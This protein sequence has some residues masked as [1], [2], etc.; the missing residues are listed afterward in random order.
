MSLECDEC[1][2]NTCTM[3]LSFPGVRTCNAKPF[4]PG[5]V[6]ICAWPFT[7]IGSRRSRQPAPWSPESQ[8]TLA[9]QPTLA[10]SSNLRPPLRGPG[11]MNLTRRRYE[12]KPCT[13]HPEKE[14]GDPVFR[15][16]TWSSHESNSVLRVMV[17]LFD[18]SRVLR[19]VDSPP[20]WWDPSDPRMYQKTDYHRQKGR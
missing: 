5:T 12:Q 19:V 8:N 7:V 11:V 18:S 9:N 17:T 10:I 20:R 6:V 16:S 1:R 13:I 4:R 14:I 3:E 15:H 2:T